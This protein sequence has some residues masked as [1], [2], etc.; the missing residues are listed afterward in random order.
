MNSRLFALLLG[1][2]VPWGTGCALEQ[3]PGKL[4]R[5][6][7][8][9]F[10]VTEGSLK[11]NSQGRLLIEAPKVRAVVPSV[12]SPVAELRFTYLGPAELQRTLA[13]GELRCQVGLKLR[14]Q[15]GCNLVYVMWRISPKPGLVV[16]VKYN[17]GQH[18]SAACGNRGYTN[19]SARQTGPVPTLAPN[20]P[21]TLRADLEGQELRVLVDGALVWAGELPREMLD[22]EGPVGLRTDNGRFELD[23]LAP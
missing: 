20:A 14:A 15:D 18:T 2:A 5:I 12:T 10:H 8:P 22:F 13:S 6:S 9:Q 7:L 3:E 23:L 16:S 17:P 19:V 4:T 11:V 1:V 21:H